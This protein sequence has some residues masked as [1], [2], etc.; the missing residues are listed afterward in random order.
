VYG[1]QYTQETA[2]NENIKF[3]LKKIYSWELKPIVFNVRIQ[4]KF[5]IYRARHKKLLSQ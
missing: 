3:K 5:H 2:A 1:E 4:S